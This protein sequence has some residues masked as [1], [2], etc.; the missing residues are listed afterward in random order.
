MT[1]TMTTPKRKAAWCA[2]TQT[3]IQTSNSNSNMNAIEKIATSACN[4]CA[5][6]AFSVINYR[7]DGKL[8]K[9]SRT[10]HKP[11]RDTI[12]FGAIHTT[13]QAGNLPD[14]EVFSRSEFDAGLNFQGS[15]G[16]GAG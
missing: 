2:N 6:A 16:Y 11:G 3:A 12:S 14:S 4:Q 7:G 5:R 10:L 8:K 1:T 15:D 13:K 9:Q